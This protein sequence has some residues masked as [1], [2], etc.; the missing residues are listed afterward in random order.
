MRRALVVGVGVA[1]LVAGCSGK[2]NDLRHYAQ[3]EEQPTTTAEAPASTTAASSSA[4]PTADPQAAQ[5]RAVAAVLTA[6]SVAEIGFNPKEAEHAASVAQLETC[7]VP[8]GKPVSGAQ[9]GLV[10]S[11]AV[12]TLTEYV[13]SYQGSTGAQVVAK[14]KQALNGCRSYPG[15]TVTPIELAKQ[16]TGV[17]SHASWC[18]HGQSYSCSMLLAKGELVARVQVVTTS[19]AKAR[20]LLGQVTPIAAAKL[21]G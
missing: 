3:D 7:A 4:K 10:G 18:E 16:P 11:S 20:D 2:P 21:N 1:V 17:D 19:D 8:L 12:T 14:V 15:G 6:E 9:I 13:G 5:L